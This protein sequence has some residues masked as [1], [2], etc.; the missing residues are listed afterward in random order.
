MMKCFA[1]GTAFA[2]ATTQAVK[3][4]WSSSESGVTEL[5]NGYSET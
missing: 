1:C 2:I 3:S 4:P 5:P